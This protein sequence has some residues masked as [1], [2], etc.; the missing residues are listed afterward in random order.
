MNFT[1]FAEIQN[2][3]NK[4]EDNNYLSRSTYLHV[5]P[6]PNFKALQE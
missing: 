3:Y 4:F 2:Y 1:S 5:N 6:N